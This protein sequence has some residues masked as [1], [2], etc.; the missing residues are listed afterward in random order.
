MMLSNLEYYC[1]VSHGCG[2]SWFLFIYSFIF[3]TGPILRVFIT[4]LVILLN[5]LYYYYYYYYYHHHYYQH[6]LLI[7]KH[8]G[9]E[10]T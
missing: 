8:A 6:S 4:K 7:Y 2:F 5:M 10:K 9:L 1:A 3:Y